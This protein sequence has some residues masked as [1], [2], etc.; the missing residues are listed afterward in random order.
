MST[1]NDPYIS[2]VVAARND[3]H[4]EN[5]LGRMQ[6][7]LGSWIRQAQRYHIPSE[8]V[9]VE[10]NPPAG[11]E[12]LKEALQW[13]ESIAPCAVRFVQVPP[14]VHASIPNA[15]A[16]HLHQMIA[17]NVGIRR[18]RGRFILATNIDIIFSAKLMQFLAE[19]TLEEDAFYRIDRHDIASDIPANAK[20]DELLAFCRSHVLSV[21]AREG[22]WSTDGD[23]L[24]PVESNDIVSPD[25]GILLGTGWYG[26]ETDTP[27][28]K[29][30]L[31]AEA[32]VV[33]TR[34]NAA[35]MILDVETGPSAREGRVEL[36]VSNEAG[37][38]VAS[39]IVEGRCLLQLNIPAGRQ[40]GK[41]RLAVRNGGMALLEDP[42][43]LDL[44]AFRI[45]WGDTVRGDEWLL[46][47]TDQKPGVN[48]AGG[49]PTPSPYAAYMRNATYLHTNACGDFTML[50]RRGWSTVRAYPEFP[51]WPMHVDSILCYS[52]HHAG[53]RE[54]ILRDPMRI[55][56]IRHQSASGATPEGEEELK[57][58]VGRKG[59]PIIDYPSLL[60]YFHHMR[61]FNMPLI[62]SGENWGLANVPLPETTL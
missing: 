47:V 20:I 17:K 19:R 15:G 32:E 60:Q 42:R 13:P 33:Y 62:F 4:G 37:K 22:T 21:S 30:Y 2:V 35:A 54:V 9:V 53:L 61:R 52:A 1:Y 27:I 11:C 7:S 51:I 36:A 8:I 48:W 6:A 31:G 14:E 26:V 3:N 23:N 59:V 16:I 43:M 45:G 46:T 57:A 10:W 18:A 24:R 50:S 29:R 44:R 12:P 39:V 41:L 56:H 34:A 25:C 55:F 38:E 5:M 28:A 49:C 40:S 58:R